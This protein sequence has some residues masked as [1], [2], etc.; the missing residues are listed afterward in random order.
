MTTIEEH[1]STGEF[2]NLP[3]TIKYPSSLKERRARVSEATYTIGARDYRHLDPDEDWESR[4]VHPDFVPVP[5]AQPFPV[6]IRDGKRRPP[7]GGAGARDYTS[8]P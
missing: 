5:R 1:D 2:G 6:H 3:E 8:E 4:P 7:P